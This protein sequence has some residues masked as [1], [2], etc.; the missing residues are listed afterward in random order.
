MVMLA[1]M[2]CSACKEG[3]PPLTDDEINAY[4]IEVPRWQVLEDAGVKKL[5]RVFTFKNFLAALAF[6]NTVGQAA[7]A[8]GHHPALLVEWGRVTVAWWTHKIHSLHKN[9]FIMA[10]MTDQLYTG[11]N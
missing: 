4:H 10:A 9:D 6:T 5:R 7:E 1:E 8:A 11:E 2:K 3:D